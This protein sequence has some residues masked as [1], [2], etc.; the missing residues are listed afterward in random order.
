MVVMIAADLGG[1]PFA[2]QIVGATVDGVS[3]VVRP[4]VEGEL[5]EFVQIKVSPLDDVCRSTAE[6]GERV[7]D[8]FFVRAVGHATAGEVEGDG[9]EFF[10]SVGLVLRL[11]FENG[12]GAVADVIVEL[13]DRGAGEFL[14]VA[15]EGGMPQRGFEH[16]GEQV[17]LVEVFGFEVEQQVTVVVLIAGE[18]VI[19][20]QVKNLACLGGIGE[21]G[22][23]GGQIGEML[24][25]RLPEQATDVGRAGA[26]VAVEIVDCRSKLR[27]WR[28]LREVQIAQYPSEEIVYALSHVQIL[29]LKRCRFSA[30]SIHLSIRL[31]SLPTPIGDRDPLE[32]TYGVGV[33][34]VALRIAMICDVF[35][36]RLK[37]I[38]WPDRPEISI[39]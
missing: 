35:P 22:I 2:E 1:I 31:I 12:E 28:A 29:C 13:I 26:V 25:A 5:V 33:H 3:V 34:L 23:A 7:A 19:D 20:R 27:I 15:P 18:E 24:L 9:A 11:V 39:S 32:R 21:C 10:V 4:A 38:P 6:E 16:D 36:T 17:R 37:D 8:Q 14:R 30:L